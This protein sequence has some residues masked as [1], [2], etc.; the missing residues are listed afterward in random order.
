MKRRA[1]YTG[2]GQL[3]DKFKKTSNAVGAQYGRDGGEFA[4]VTGSNYRGGAADY[5]LMTLAARA[6]P[7]PMESLSGF[8]HPV[9]L[10]CGIHALVHDAGN[11]HHALV[12]RE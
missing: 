12:Q 7:A 5:H 10:A 2:K 3:R 9:T 11:D 6:K 1:L 8:P 4:S